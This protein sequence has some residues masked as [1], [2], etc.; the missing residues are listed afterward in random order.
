MLQLNTKYESKNEL[1]KL[2][3]KTS[4]AISKL[5]NY[6]L[7]TIKDKSTNVN[8]FSTSD[9]INN[10]S[11]NI[12]E[13]SNKS[14]KSLINKK[15]SYIC[16]N[17]YCINNIKANTSNKTFISS[18][19]EKEES[20]SISNS[21]NNNLTSKNKS[22][23]CKKMDDIKNFFDQDLNNKSNIVNS[24]YDKRRFTILDVPGASDNNSF[25]ISNKYLDNY[26]VKDYFDSLRY[27]S[28]SKELIKL[29]IKDLLVKNSKNIKAYISMFVLV[30]SK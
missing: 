27:V 12:I 18:N 14:I 19:T 5:S 20:L 13:K 26:F 6:T 16:N 3:H 8:N 23:V 22:V 11:F 17:C 25:C 24:K 21:N 15:E 29:T 30:S 2:N 4:N 10:S 7:C 28:E 1:N 9:N